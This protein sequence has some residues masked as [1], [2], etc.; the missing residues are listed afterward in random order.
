MQITKCDICKKEIKDYSEEINVSPL[1]RILGFVFCSN[2]GKP[3][4][5]F[6]R[7]NNLIEKKAT[8]K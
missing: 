3:V 1:G 5:K 8:R 4:I 7:K 2:C 6:L